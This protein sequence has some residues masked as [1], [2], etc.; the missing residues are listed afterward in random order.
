MPALMPYGRANAGSDVSHAA[1]GEVRGRFQIGSRGARVSRW[2]RAYEGTVTD[3]KLGEA[4]LIAEVSRSVSI[5]AWH[6]L[7]ES[8]AGRKTTAVSYR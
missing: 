2:Y 5:A 1:A 7:L 8:A 4:A 6:C 3:A